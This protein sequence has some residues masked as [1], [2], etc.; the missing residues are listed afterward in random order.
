MSTQL[1]GI[2]IGREAAS[3][4]V[5]RFARDPGV[6]EHRKASGP[7]DT[8]A[9]QL[10]SAIAAFA[11]VTKRQAA[12]S[13]SDTAA[14]LEALLMILEDEELMSMV[15][16]HLQLGWDGATALYL[17]LD[18]LGEMMGDDDDFASRVGDLRGMARGIAA[19]LRGIEANTTIPAE[20]AWVVVAQDLTPVDTA[21]FTDSVVGVVTELGGPT[22]HTAII[23][24]ARNIPAVVGA[25]GAMGLAEAEWVLVDPA[26]NRVVPG[27]DLT[28]ATTPISFIPTHDEPLA[29]VRANIGSLADAQAAA[30]TPARGVGLFRTE[31]LYLDRD[32]APSMEL[33]AAEFAAVFRA[34]PAGTIIVR[35]I[36]AGSDKPVPFLPNGVEENPALGVR[37]FRLSQ[38]H[39]D[40]Q[41]DQLSAIK[42]AID[43]TGRD[44][45]VMAPM[46]ATVSE[47]EEFRAMAKQVGLRSIGIMVETPAI[48]PMIPELAGVVDFLS[49]GTNDLSQ[50]LFAADRQHPAM[51]SLVDPW[52]PGLLRTID[53]LVQAANLVGLPVGVCGESA[54]R[55]PPGR[56]PCRAWGL[57]GQHGTLGG[58]IGARRAV[59]GFAGNC[60]RRCSPGSCADIGQRRS[61]RCDRPF[62]DLVAQLGHL[63]GVK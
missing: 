63:A 44:V 29:T 18:D 26:G 2:G 21:L 17:A 45:Q 62:I 8:E 25:T 52:Q 59:L 11:E 9:D 24:R 46:I 58:G 5:L 53:V 55:P 27:A 32:T 54:R 51:G 20:G 19:S 30:A 12:A 34:A 33:Q 60:C 35:T 42:A 61:R 48:V 6:E 4:Q 14:I 57:I 22:S 38:A 23:C 31:V 37:G 56:G 50:Y 13:D 36:D 16:A 28:L 3:G 7:P 40:F 49:V 1:S 10:R 47:A 43:A 39:R 15:L 41:M